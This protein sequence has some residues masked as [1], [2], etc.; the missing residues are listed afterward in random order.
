MK[1][2]DLRI[3]DW[4]DKYMPL[5]DEFM[6]SKEHPKI[7]LTLEEIKNHETVTDF[8]EDDTYLYFTCDDFNVRIDKNR[9]KEE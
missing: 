1:F 2:V 5:L 6:P 8:R 7:D 4:R 3:F 9:L